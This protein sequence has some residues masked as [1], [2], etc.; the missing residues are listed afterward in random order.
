MGFKEE[1][2]PLVVVT[3]EGQVEAAADTAVVVLGVSARADQAAAAYRQVAEVLNR[4]VRALTDLGVPLDQMQTGLITLQ[5]IYDRE[6][7]VG[8]E[9]TATVRVTLRDLSLVGPVIDQAVAAGANRLL[10]V[11][12]EV[13]EP[14]AYEARALA[15]AVQDAQQKAMVVARTA[16]IGLGP[17]WRAEAEPAPEP[18]FPLAARVAAVEAI[19][20]LPGTLVLTRRVR[21]EYL[22]QYP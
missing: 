4:I 5:P 15:R 9:A 14:A 20:I 16:G 19:P 13:R 10:G 7:L 21:V 18:V 11:T 22:V 17:V 6:Q 1:E 8:Y 2:P 12:F 3:G